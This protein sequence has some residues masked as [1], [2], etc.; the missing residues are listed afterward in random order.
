MA[1]MN[2][3]I[4]FLPRLLS[5]AIPERKILGLALAGLDGQVISGYGFSVTLHFPKDKRA[6]LLDELLG[7][8]N[9][10]QD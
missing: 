3:L 6:E 2:Q 5:K 1:I 10:T 4:Q 7:V 9:G 8:P